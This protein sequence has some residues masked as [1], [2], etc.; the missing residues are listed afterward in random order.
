MK[1]ILANNQGQKFRD[2]YRQLAAK[3]AMPFDYA[4]YKALLFIFDTSS[5]NAV[6]AIN[7]KDGRSLQDYDG[8]YING[9]LST[10]ELAATVAVC[11]DALGVPYVNHELRNAPSLSKLSMYAKLAAAGV[12]LPYTLCGTK[13]AL[14]QAGDYIRPEL[15]PAVLKRAD[16]DRGVDNFKV[17]DYDD[18][19][20]MLETAEDRSLWLLQS[21]IDNDGFYTVT[22]Y[23]GQPTFCIFRSLETRPDGNEHK[24]HMYKPKGG[25]NASLREIAGLP[26]ALTATGQRA[27]QAMDRQI[28]SVDLIIDQASDQPYVLEVNYNPQL[29][30]IETF[31][32]V[33]Q[34]AFLNFMQKDWH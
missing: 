19:C 33:R 2:F 6:Q 8:V 24:A 31:K 9:Y 32:D 23:D 15:F 26:E 3:S 21:Y 34:E 7:V 12:S 10:Y 18:V 28:A 14:L 30:T 13:A 17:T 11:C 27:V 20:A 22:Y 4:G 16:A 25:A 5:Q 1:L 29:V